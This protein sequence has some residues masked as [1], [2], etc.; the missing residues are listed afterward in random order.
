MILSTWLAEG[1]RVVKIQKILIADDDKVVR[2]VLSKIA[3]KHGIEVKT[4]EDG[5]EVEDVLSCD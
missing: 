5:E 1:D 4:V 3:E 2:T